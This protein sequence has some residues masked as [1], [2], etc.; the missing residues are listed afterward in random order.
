MTKDEF[1]RKHK[2]PVYRGTATTM[3]DEW[4]PIENKQEICNRLREALA[5]MDGGH[6]VK[7]LH[8]EPNAEGRET[9]TLEYEGLRDGE[10]RVFDV[11][12]KRGLDIACMI[13]KELR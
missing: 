2:K 1:E 12:G 10:R 9:V 4:K 8:Y 3:S 5:V 6:R 11:T 13:I 7:R